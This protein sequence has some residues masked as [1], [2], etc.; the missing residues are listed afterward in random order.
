MALIIEDG[1][2]VDNANSYVDI[3]FLDTFVVT[4]CLI[5]PEPDAAKEV[6]LILAFDY[7]EA[8]RGEFKGTKT[9]DDQPNQWPRKDVRIDAVAFANDAIPAELQYAQCQLV[10]EQ[11]AGIVL[12]PKPRTSTNEGMVVEK[13][14]G[15]LTKRFAGTSIGTV[16]P[17]TRIRIASVEAYLDE[18]LKASSGMVTHRV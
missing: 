10:I 2:G 4:R 18:L 8:R 9:E 7:L 15:P 13:T 16:S 17:Y 5:S 12:Y 14:V 6:F 11:N 1:T 3:A